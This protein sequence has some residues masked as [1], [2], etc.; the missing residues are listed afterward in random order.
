[1]YMAV[2]RICDSNSIYTNTQI[3]DFGDF[4]PADHSYLNEVTPPFANRLRLMKFLKASPSGNFVKK[5]TK[6]FIR[7]NAPIVSIASIL[8]LT[9][10]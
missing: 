6:N 7:F 5:F 1:M 9:F 10:I 8:S 3:V 4:P 2:Y